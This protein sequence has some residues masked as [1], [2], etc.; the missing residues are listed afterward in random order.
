MPHSSTWT[1]GL[2]ARLCL[3][4]GLTLALIASACAAPT[5]MP[6]RNPESDA[7]RATQAKRI[8]VAIRS[9]PASMAGTRTN[10]PGMTGSIPGL[11]ALE[12][13]VHAGMMHTDDKGLQL[14]Q[15][16]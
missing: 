3:S 4:F 6:A 7:P 2:R 8:S 16:A 10:P 11:E 13:M 14:P 15:L 12:E 9:A 1:P 5:S